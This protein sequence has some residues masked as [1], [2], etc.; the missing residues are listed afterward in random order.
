MRNATITGALTCLC[1]PVTAQWT[2]HVSED[3]FTDE[4]IWT[5]SVEYETGGHTYI[6]FANCRDSESLSIGLTGTHMNPTGGRRANSVTRYHFPVRFDDGTPSEKE[7]TAQ[8]NVLFLSVS[9][10]PS[11]RGFLLHSFVKS[12]AEGSRVRMKFPEYGGD[13]ILDFTMA[14]AKDALLELAKGCGIAGLAEGTVYVDAEG[15]PYETLADML[16]DETWLHSRREFIAS[17]E[18]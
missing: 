18:N 11:A 1:L 4:R 9:M 8:S 12:F 13:V 15:K 6:L 16:E 2:H 14:G 3:D 17:G 5:S 7:F 10:L